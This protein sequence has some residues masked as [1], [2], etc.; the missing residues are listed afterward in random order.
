MISQLR[1]ADQFENSI[2]LEKISATGV[3]L[4]VGIRMSELS[5]KSL[6]KDCKP[7][8]IQAWPSTGRV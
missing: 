3:F 2:M 6:A 7:G 1:T 8:F 5:G 4:H